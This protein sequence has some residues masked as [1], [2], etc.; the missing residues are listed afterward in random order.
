MEVQ[1]SFYQIPRQVI[2]KYCCCCISEKT[3]RNVDPS[4]LDDP[5]PEKLFETMVTNFFD[6]YVE[7][8]F[9]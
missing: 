8:N 2:R 1:I 7:L 3:N 4:Q 5:L 6:N 9:Y